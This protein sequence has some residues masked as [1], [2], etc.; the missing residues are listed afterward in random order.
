MAKFFKF[1]SMMDAI[2][3]ILILGRLST[4][5]PF[6]YN[7]FPGK[8]KTSLNLPAMILFI[9]FIISYFPSFTWFGDFIPAKNMPEIYSYN[10]GF[11]SKA[12][13]LL[14]IC[15]SI[16]RFV[17]CDNL[18]NNFEIL[19][20][21]E[22]ILYNL[23][24][25]RNFKRLKFILFRSCMIQQ[26]SFMAFIIFITYN[27]FDFNSWDGIPHI[28]ASFIPSY[29][30][31]MSQ[32][33]CSNFIFLIWS[34]LKVLNKEILKIFVTIPKGKPDATKVYRFLDFKS[35]Q[36]VVEDKLDMIWKVYANLCKCSTLLSDYFS[37]MI[38]AIFSVSFLNSLF[39]AF[40][41]VNIFMAVS[42]GE[43]IDSYILG[44]RLA[45][46]IGTTL[47]MFALISVCN[48]CEIEVSIKLVY[49]IVYNIS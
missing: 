41:M 39:N 6:N 36:S 1:D 42:S 37:I 10:E 44:M 46:F 9:F 27:S 3:P 43:N 11:Q 49:I 8:S 25:T 18:A 38:F 34:N 4:I 22:K 48:Y 47:N 21:N 7:I 29:Q 19:Q 5:A 35:R 16:F 40:Y 30:N 28:A 23:G 31:A 2:K 20:R 45:R 12:G 32:Y 14:F 17:S 26:T 33:L 15:I 13:C 24:Y